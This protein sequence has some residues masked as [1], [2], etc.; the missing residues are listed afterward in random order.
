MLF[1][2]GKKMSDKNTSFESTDKDKMESNLSS[3]NFSSPLIMGILNI[4][5][6]SFFDGGEYYS[7]ETWLNRVGKMV[8]EGVDIIDVGGMSTRPGAK[9]ISQE[10][11][12]KRVL[13]PLRLIKKKFPQVPV[14]VD[15]FR[16]E[17]A[18]ASVQ[19]GANLINDISGGTYDTNM[20]KTIA[21][22]GVPYVLMH[23]VG[24]PETMQK[25]PVSQGIVEKVRVF[26]EDRVN[27]LFDFGVRD[28]IL[29][30]G[31]GFGKTLECNYSILKNM[32]KTRINGLPL[33]AGIS[34]KSMINK[35]L[36]IEPAEA[37]NGTSALNMFAL[38]NG[39]NI[40]RVHDVKEAKEVI[41]LY[42][43]YKQV[44]C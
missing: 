12:L 28:I 23:I 6:D 18:T 26:F 25:N 24:T 14:S 8:D 37:L 43:V 32:E 44:E 35:V 31:F 40:L 20:F 42:E 2:N 10:E 34:R 1:F 5:P 15:T 36:G 9:F 7:E 30:P 3:L 38:Q 33:L 4:T 22:I 29:D 11:E 13:P 17:V 19:E 27:R 21:H 16:S 39:A 41:K